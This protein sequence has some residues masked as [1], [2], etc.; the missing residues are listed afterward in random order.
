MVSSHVFQRTLT[1]AIYRKFHT[2]SS[3]S[4][5]K[6]SRYR[7]QCARDSYKTVFRLIL[8]LLLQLFCLT[9]I[10]NDE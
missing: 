1:S 10:R 4:Y 6:I 3:R 8:T 9:S 7:E 5:Q 2:A